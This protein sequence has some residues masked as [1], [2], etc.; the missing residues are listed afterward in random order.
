MTGPSSFDDADELERVTDALRR[1]PAVDP[2]AVDRVVASALAR[3]RAR[4][5]RRAWLAR[6]AGLALAVGLAGGGVW[7]G[8]RGV[9]G[10]DQRVD[11]LE[12]RHDLPAEPRA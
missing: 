5:S 8:R 9:T 11:T 2:R 6:A 12:Q 3:R 4:Q 1:L 10:E 7:V